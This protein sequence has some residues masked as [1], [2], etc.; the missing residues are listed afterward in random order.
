MLNT[1]FNHLQ[2]QFKNPS[3]TSRGVLRTKDSWIIE[4][5]DLET[6]FIGIGECSIIDGLSI[7]DRSMIENRIIRVNTLFNS[8]TSFEEVIKH[9]HDFPAVRF[10]FEMALLNIRNSKE[11][12]YYDCDFI[13]GTGIP[14]NGLVWMGAREFMF[15]QIKEKLDLG[16]DCIKLKIAAIDFEEELAMIEYIRRQFS[17]DLIEL[18]VDANGGILPVEALEKLKLLSE[19]DIHSIEQPIEVEQWDDMAALCLASPIDIAL[20]E[21]LIRLT[22]EENR[23]ACLSHIKP[24]YIILKPSLLGG[25][26]ESENW[27]S[28]ADNLGIDYWATSALESNIGL[29]AIAQWT[30]RLGLENHQGL[31]T[32]GL[33][34]NNIAP[35]MK[36]ENGFLYF[37]QTV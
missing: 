6:S 12:V 5:T 13:N 15:D 34:T 23:I 21:E 9:T 18:R 3:G 7:D 28:I 29:N 25:F 26:A 2:L 32:G 1:S 35:F 8:D 16:F 19:Y 36:V 14:I 37:N 20:D 27:I 33:Y 11:N 10:A 31:G 30:S 17:S 22:S 4:L 24:Q